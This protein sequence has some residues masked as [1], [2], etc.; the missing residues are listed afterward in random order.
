M[1][2]DTYGNGQQNLPKTLTDIVWFLQQQNITLSHTNGDGRLKSASDEAIILKAINS[3]F[4]IM[5]GDLRDW[6]DFGFEE[7]GIFCPVN[8]KIST[9]ITADN[10]NCKL[11]I[12]YA[13]TGQDPKQDPNFRNEIGWEEYFQKLSADIQE[14][15]VDYYFLI[16]NKTNTKDIFAVSL[17][18]LNILVPNGNNLPFQAI[19]NK[20]RQHV[21]RSFTEA[22]IFLLSHFEESLRLRDNPHLYFQKYFDGNA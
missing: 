4:N 1:L 15:N 11:G 17:K 10:L 16:I 21:P 18:G 14:N 12:Y 7:N 3:K 22:K 9:L 19:W 20:N 5:C 6:F 2:N 13:L 8:I